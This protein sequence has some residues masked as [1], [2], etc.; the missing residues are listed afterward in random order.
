MAAFIKRNHIIFAIFLFLLI[1]S[2]N[3]AYRIGLEEF[4]DYEAYKSILNGKLPY[5]DFRWLYGPLGLFINALLLKMFGGELIVLRYMAI[6]AG[7]I[8]IILSYRICRFLMPKRAAAIAAFFAV[9]S[10]YNLPPHTYNHYYGMISNLAAI[11]M[12]FRFIKTRRSRSLFFAGVLLNI[13]LLIHPLTFGAEMTASVVAWLLFFAFIAR[14]GIKRLLR[15][16]LTFLA[17]T[18]VFTV[19]LYAFMARTVPLTR[20]FEL[21]WSHVNY[22]PGY[23]I[24]FPVIRVFAPQETGG[25]L[26]A[27]RHA[28]FNGF[29]DPLMFYLLLFAVPVT[30]AVSLLYSLRKQRDDAS[31][32]YL[33]FLT[34]VTVSI[35][36]YFLHISYIGATLFLVARYYIQPPIILLSFLIHRLYTY[37][38]RCGRS[39]LR[40]VIKVSSIS[41]VAVFLFFYHGYRISDFFLKK[42]YTVDMTPIKGLRITDD[43][44]KRYVE[45]SLYILSNS[46]EGDTLFVA[47]YDPAYYS[48]TGRESIFP[49]DVYITMTPYFMEMSSRLYPRYEGGPMRM[50]DLIIKRIENEKPKFIV[51]CVTNRYRYDAPSQDLL[52]KYSLGPKVE[53]YL[54]N[55]YVLS[56]AFS[57]AN[58]DMEVRI[59]HLRG[60]E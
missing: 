14:T 20:V 54:N 30:A 19:P 32:L 11:L 12:L 38:V 55:N 31:V 47:D 23:G 9:F 27:L 7:C 42:W 10:F 51:R 57:F 25:G 39:T 46:A 3:F 6:F 29:V 1:Q 59:Y 43:D 58:N 56:K 40:S 18:A 33:L 48:L 5:L 34:I 37:S 52:T 26:Y 45:P 50:E 22:G 2:L 60:R 8:A 13:S 35:V 16:V 17:G 36:L 21:L 4:R 15:F 41:F 49:E 53:E 24:V 44:I 28:I